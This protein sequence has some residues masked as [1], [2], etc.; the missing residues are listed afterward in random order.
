MLS[1]RTGIL[2]RT[3]KLPLYARHEVEYAWIVDTNLRTVEV[4]RLKDG[5]WMLSSVHGGNEP[6]RIEPFEAVEFPMARL[7]LSEAPPA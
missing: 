6:A 4:F 7:W 2:D 3:R 5:Q 1:P